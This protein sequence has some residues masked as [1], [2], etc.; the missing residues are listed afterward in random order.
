MDDPERHM[1]TLTSMAEAFNGVYGYE[2]RYAAI[3]WALDEL[4]GLRAECQLKDMLINQLMD[5]QKREVE[6]LKDIE[7]ENDNA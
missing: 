2:H 5:E 7:W 1:E 3:D 4:R 6:Y